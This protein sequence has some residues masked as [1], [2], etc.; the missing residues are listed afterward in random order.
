LT[1]LIGTLLETR[2]WDVNRHKHN[3]VVVA[4]KIATGPAGT[5]H[6]ATGGPYT[7]V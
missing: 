1:S 4:D 3:N 7:A 6:G 2:L 5:T